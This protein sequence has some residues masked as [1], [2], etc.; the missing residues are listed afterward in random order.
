MQIHFQKPKT[1]QKKYNIEKFQFKQ[2]V[3]VKNHKSQ[4]FLMLRILEIKK[5]YEK[6]SKN[7]YVCNKYITKLYR[8]S[9][10]EQK[11]KY[12]IY[13]WDKVEKC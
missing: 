13:E 5:Y 4:Y 9:W 12:Y 6:I 1:K 8:I 10:Y 2:C 7:M 3:T 11:E